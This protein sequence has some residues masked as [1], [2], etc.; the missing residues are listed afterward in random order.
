MTTIS[1]QLKNLITQIKTGEQPL[2]RA[3]AERIGAEL[4]GIDEATLDEL[5]AIDSLE[6]GAPKATQTGRASLPRRIDGRQGR[7]AQRNALKSDRKPPA[8][9]SW[10]SGQARGPLNNKV[11]TE[12][13]LQQILQRTGASFE[14]QVRHSGSATDLKSLSEQEARY[15]SLREQLKADPDAD[16]DDDWLPKSTPQQTMAK[17]RAMQKAW[18]GAQQGQR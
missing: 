2:D 1:P 8:V 4:E 3:T 17:W 12:A 14:S 9:A 11:A 15:R 10:V 16:D 5:K 7:L 18:W 6:Q 13:G